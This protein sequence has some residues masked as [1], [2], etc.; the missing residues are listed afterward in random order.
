MCSDSETDTDLEEAKPAQKGMVAMFTFPTPRNYP[1]ILAQRKELKCLLPSDVSKQELADLFE[2]I[3]KKNKVFQKLT[4]FV[5]VQEPHKRWNKAASPQARY[6]HIHIVCYMQNTFT[7]ACIRK[8]LAA[9]GVN[10]WWTTSLCGWP[11]YLRYV[12]CDSA[13]KLPADIDSDPLF[14]PA[15]SKDKALEVARSMSKQQKGRKQNAA[16]LCDAEAAAA[17]ASKRRKK[18]SFTEFTD[19]VLER[20]IKTVKRAWK[21]AWEMKAS[22]D[23]LLHEYLGNARDIAGEVRKA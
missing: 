4:H 19:M 17:P 21:V 8:D 6:T 16:L 5:V 22:G 2:E 7:H 9:A 18:L 3:L 10:A 15:W 14:V 23:V 1:K 12:L 11:S 20:D 13:K